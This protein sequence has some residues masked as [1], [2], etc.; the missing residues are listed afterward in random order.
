MYLSIT[1]CI[2]AYL[3]EILA[4]KTIFHFQISSLVS[5]QLLGQMCADGQIDAVRYKCLVS[6]D[7]IRSV[8]RLV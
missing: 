7:M 6:L 8:A 4:I 5:L 1:I 2:M 3:L